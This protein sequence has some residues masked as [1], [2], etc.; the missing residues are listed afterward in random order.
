MRSLMTRLRPENLGDIM[1]GISLFRPGPM[2]K[3]PDYIEYKRNHPERVQYAH[4]MLE[5]SL[6]DTYGCMVYQEQVMEIVRDM[7]GYSLA[8]SD[9]VRRT[10]SKRKWRP[11]SGN[12][13]SLSMA[14]TAWTA[15]SNGASAKRWRRKFSTR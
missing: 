1:V 2:S 6:K 10:M 8:R 15:P 12:G 4:P 14:A 11:W 7:A 5:K 3:I 13:K 9:D